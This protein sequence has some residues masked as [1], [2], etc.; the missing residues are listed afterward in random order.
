MAHITN[1]PLWTLALL[2]LVCLPAWAASDPMPNELREA[3]DATL[4]RAE[5]D[6]PN[7][8]RASNPDNRFALQF[9]P[10]AVKVQPFGKSGW[11]FGLKL[12]GYG[13]PGHVQPVKPA[14]LAMEDQRVEY[15]RGAITEWYENRP[16]GL[17]QGFTLDEPPANTGRFVL[18]LK[19][20]GGLRPKLDAHAQALSLQAANGATVL[21]YHGLKVTDALGKTLPAKLALAGDAIQI[22]VHAQGAAWP[23]TVDPLLSNEQKLTPSDGAADDRFGSSVALSGDTALVGAPTAVIGFNGLR[24]TA[25]AAYVFTRSGTVWSQQA[26]LTAASANFSFLFGSSVA[27]SGDTALIGGINSSGQGVA[28]VFTRSGTVWSQQAKLTASDGTADDGG[29]L[30][31]LSGDTALIGVSNK[32]V[33]SNSKQG[34][35]YVFTRSGA[36]WSQQAKLTASDGAADNYFGC[37]V[38]LSGDT[39]LIGAYNKTVGSNESQGATYLFTRSGTAWSQQQ[40]L[41]ASD[42]A[43]GDWFGNSVALSGDTALVGADSKTVGSN[44]RQGAAYVFTRSGTAWSQQTELIVSGRRVGSSVALSGDTALVGAYSKTADFTSLEGPEG[45]AYL[46]TRSDTVW[47]QQQILN[48]G[49]AGDWFGSSVALSGNTALVGAFGINNLQGAAYLFLPASSTA[50]PSPSINADGTTLKISLASGSNAGTGADWWVVAYASWGHWYY[51]VYPSQWVD[52]GTSLSGVK[53]AYQGPLQD[54]SGLTL[55]NLAG[56]PSG[57]YVLYFGVDTNLNS[58]LDYDQLYSSKFTYNAP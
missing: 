42:G 30:V 23:V 46:F 48:D 44:F 38:A 28:Y 32:T 54:L 9:G 13:T 16:E 15:R 22:R 18:A 20:E 58:T 49:A 47:S 1:K 34:A 52:M 26:K 50:P 31:A 10:Q 43:A 12:T 41:T 24:I 45:A 2:A 14:Q 37:S 57:Q 17:E 33:G 29:F 36:A 56:L 40:E 3:V 11:R 19:L 35:A 53:P 25:G 5:P 51:Y 27:L 6:G 8:Y 21:R 39:A 7:R 4:R 55:S